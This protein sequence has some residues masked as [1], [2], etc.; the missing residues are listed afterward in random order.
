M[1]IEMIES[2]E[3]NQDLDQETLLNFLDHTVLLVSQAQTAEDIDLLMDDFMSEDVQQILTENKDLF[4]LLNAVWFSS[5]KRVFIDER[6][7][8][9]P[10]KVLWLPVLF[11]KLGWTI[12]DIETFEQANFTFRSQTQNKNDLYKF[13]VELFL[14]GLKFELDTSFKLFKNKI[15]AIELTSK[16]D[17]NQI[18]TILSDIESL[19]W[20]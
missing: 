12:E 4:S 17:H 5:F 8:S 3:I 13:L 10:L 1:N 7:E 9:F 14:N 19:G 2:P 15:E 18:A 6:S 16:K 11:K 20:Q